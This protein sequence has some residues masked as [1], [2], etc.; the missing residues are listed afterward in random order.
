M[1]RKKQRLSSQNR[2][3]RRTKESRKRRGKAESESKGKH[4]WNG[5][6]SE[7]R[8]DERKR[9]ECQ[10]REPRR[11]AREIRQERMGETVKPKGRAEALE[12]PLRG[13]DRKKRTEETEAE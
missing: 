1:E 2:K 7:T 8:K 4:L 10:V 13:K 6:G 5:C 12:K 11:N 3:M 9:T